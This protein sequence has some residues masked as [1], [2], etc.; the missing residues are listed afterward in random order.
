MSDG[1]LSHAAKPTFDEAARHYQAGRFVEAAQF[2]GRIL[3]LDPMHADSLHLLGVIA[4]RGGRYST[5]AELIGRAIGLRKEDPY[6]QFNM[7]IALHSLGRIDE[8]IAYYQGAL[9]LKPDYAEAH[10]NLGSALIAKGDVGAATS[11]YERAI[12]INPDHSEAHNNL[13][14]ILKDQGRF[15]E[16]MAHFGRTLSIDPGRAEAWYNVGVALAAQG[17]VD[18]TAEHYERALALKPEYADAHNNLGTMRAAQ[19]AAEDA[20]AHY[21]RA[22]AINPN[23]AEAHNNLGTVFKDQGRFDDAMLHYE[24]ALAIKPD[25]TEVHYNRAEVK[26]FQPGDADLT[27]LEAM[28]ARDDWSRGK[29]LYIH[30]ALAK[31]CEDIKDYSRGFEH[32]RKGNALKRAQIRY[33]ENGVAELFRRTSAVFDASLLR[34]FEG[35]GDPSSVPIFVLGMPRS[36]SSLVEQI[37]ASH[38]RILGA[39][40]LTALEAVTRKEFGAGDGSLPY[41]ECVP[42][43]DGAAL[44]RLGKSYLSYLPHLPPFAGGQVRIVDKTPDNFF[45]IGL[46]R[47]I[48]PNARIIHTMRDPVDTCVSCYSKL[49]ATGLHFSYD[50]A[51]LGRYY[52]RYSE[53]M[54][55]WRSVLS[56][57][58]MLDVAYE[59]VVDDLEGQARRLIDYCG[60]P[61]DDRCIAFHKTS[62][63][64]KTAS[65]VQVRKP[66]FRTSLQRW[67]RYEESLTPLLDELAELIANPAPEKA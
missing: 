63:P 49:F 53:L 14:N 47:L 37:L 35:E 66:L 41:P 1:A 24:R 50:L 15:D 62:R 22:F 28:A 10:N 60:L 6:Y 25:Y 17:K 44:R 21:E 36:G 59:D 54:T 23:H 52:R 39:G 27:A 43:L 5:A 34:R 3:T 11:H 13:G 38:P 51:E 12:A 67:R 40:E 31:A 42:A 46:I 33:D 55:H 19:G 4:C 57:G 30:F 32:L 64:V 45:R 29:A 8:A 9:A 65:A 26:T 61:W 58:A 56:P 18:E 48:L 16:A 20:A 2:C 7:A